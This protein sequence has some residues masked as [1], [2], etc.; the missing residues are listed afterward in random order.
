MTRV[1][2]LGGSVVG[3]NGKTRPNWRTGDRSAKTVTVRYVT[4]K[5]RPTAEKIRANT[6]RNDGHR[7]Y[8]ETRGRLYA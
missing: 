3:V 2:Y 5:P 1:T 4:P 7:R 8:N 6:H